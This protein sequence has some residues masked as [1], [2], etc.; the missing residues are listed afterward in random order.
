VSFEVVVVPRASR[1][2]I[3]GLHGDRLKIT[4]AAPPVDGEANAELIATLAKAL[5]V[6]KR[7]VQIAQG[8]HNKHKTVRVTGV[9]ADHVLRLGADAA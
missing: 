1:S 3:A 2:K 7:A 9:S 6:P 8:E 4:L 5:G